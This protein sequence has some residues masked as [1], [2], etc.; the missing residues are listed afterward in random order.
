MITLYRIISKSTVELI[1][2]KIITVYGGEAKVEN[3][4]V[5]DA[6]EP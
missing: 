3:T 1:G 5:I 4:I 6:K 2:N